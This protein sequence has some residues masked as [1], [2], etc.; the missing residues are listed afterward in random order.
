MT[1]LIAPNSIDFDE[2]LKELQDDIIRAAERASR[3]GLCD[4]V[5]IRELHQQADDAAGFPELVAAREARA[6]AQR[7]QEQPGLRHC[8]GFTREELDTPQN[9]SDSR[10]ADRWEARNPSIYR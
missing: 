4:E 9:R 5:I 1:K 8:K 2:A 6:K 7:L 10:D 3:N